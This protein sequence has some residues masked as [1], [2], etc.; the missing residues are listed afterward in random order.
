M[1]YK[2]HVTAM[3]SSRK[4]PDTALSW[5]V[6]AS[7]DDHSSS[8]VTERACQVS[9][10]SQA[11]PRPDPTRDTARLK[12]QGGFDCEFVEQPPEAFQVECPICL[13]VLREP[14]L[15]SCCGY[16]YCRLCI[17]RIQQDSPCPTCSEAGFS[18][19]PNKGL[20]RSL[21]ALHVR[22][23]YRKNG[24]QWTREL[25]ELDKHL[26]ENPEL[27]EQLVGCEFAE[28]ECHHCRELFQRHCVSTH[29][30]EQCIRRPF[31]CDYCGNYE[32]DYEAVVTRHWPVCDSR[33][34]PCPSE[35][36]AYPERRNLEHHVNKEC[37]LAVVACDFHYAGCE[38]QLPRTDMRLHL[39]EKLVAHTS[40]L[41]AYGQR[42]A[43]LNERKMY[44]KDKAITRLT[45]ELGENRRKIEA[46]E[47]ENE[48][49]KRCLAE[50]TDEMDQKLKSV[51]PSLPV[52]FTMADFDQHRKGKITWYSPP[53][54]TY[55][56]GYKMF[57]K[58]VPDLHGHSD[59]SMFVGA[60][61][62]RGEFDHLLKWPFEGSIAFEILNQLED[63]EHRR[64]TA[65]FVGS[66]MA[67][68][69]VDGDTAEKGRGR[70]VSYE[71][72]KNI[73]ARHCQYLKD[74][75]LHFRVTQ[76]IN[77]D[78]M[79]LQRQCL[80]IESRVCV[81]PIEFAM[82]DFE[83]HKR[84]NDRWLSPSLYSHTGGYRLCIT[85]FANGHWGTHLGVFVHV[86]QGVFDDSLKWPLRGNINIRLLNQLQNEGHYEMPVSFSHVTLNEFAGR[87]TTHLVNMRYGYNRFISHDQLNYNLAT[88]CQYL[89]NDCLQ[90]RVTA[91][92][93]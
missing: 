25:G 90:F 13:S 51:L 75:C 61:L 35:C 68:R 66:K 15:V 80:A 46:L 77:R 76:F 54:Y 10:S 58:V 37:P 41:A 93:I 88:N 31:S 73:P 55:L 74:D 83:R 59:S 56:Q 19:F 42:I 22:C 11:S 60:C 43:E 7:E 23:S 52:E 5:I 79:Q 71:D 65:V 20:K 1:T 21:C 18:V 9:E 4:S 28:V 36:G 47:R 38:V 82:T 63:R 89:C 87:T 6:M 40:L 91:Q 69:V 14:Y 27:G 64:L 34:I 3:M 33:Q 70:D 48:V 2:S 67:C 32:A 44:E 45:S 16:N 50:K 30:I 29:Q 57:L 17:E 39:T 26:N 72:L 81:C 53:F 84:D 8:V 24:C 85:V 12:C 49:L 86:M 78:V 92:L 62:M